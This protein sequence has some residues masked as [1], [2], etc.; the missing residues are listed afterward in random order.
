MVTIVLHSRSGS[1][2]KSSKAK[3]VTETL[4]DVILDVCFLNFTVGQEV[5]KKGSKAKIITLKPWIIPF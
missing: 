1:K 2:Q 5:N 3:I 4:D